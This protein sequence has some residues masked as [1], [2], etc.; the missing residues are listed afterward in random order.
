MPG[1]STFL[2]VVAAIFPVV[3]PPGSALI[4]LGLTQGCAFRGIVSMDF[5]AS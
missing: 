1:L 3:N 4:F 5:T 2:L